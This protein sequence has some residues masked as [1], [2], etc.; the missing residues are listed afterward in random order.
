MGVIAGRS[1]LSGFL[2]SP[3]KAAE[4]GCGSLGWIYDELS[5]GFNWTFLA[6]LGVSNTLCRTLLARLSE[7]VPGREGG[8]GWCMEA[9][10]SYAL[11]TALPPGSFILASSLS[12]HNPALIP[13]LLHGSALEDPPV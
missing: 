8:R 5:L 3:S 9:Q 1:L 12:L 11:M 13:L 10:L 4:Q 6:A 2:G 7:N